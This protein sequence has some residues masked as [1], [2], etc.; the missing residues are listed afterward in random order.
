MK[1]TFTFLFLLSFLFV[2]AQDCPPGDVTFETQAQ[3]NSF[4]QQFP[5]CQVINGTLTL[6][7]TSNDGY[8]NI[9]NLSPLSNIT[10][11][12][13]DLVLSRLGNV[14]TLS[15]LSNLQ[16]VNGN[17][18]LRRNSNYYT[19]YSNFNYVQG[20]NSLTTITGTL[21]IGDFLKDLSGMSNLTQLGGIAMWYSNIESFE[22]LENITTLNHFDVQYNSILSFNGLQNLQTINGNF[23]LDVNP[24]TGEIIPLDLMSNLSNITTVTGD[25]YIT[26]SRQQMVNNMPSF[27]INFLSNLTSVGQNFGLVHFNVGDFSALSNL[28]SVGGNAGFSVYATSL[29]G[30][31]N[32]V[33]NKELYLSIDNV[34]DFS[35]LEDFTN[36]KNLTIHHCADLVSLNGLQ[37]LISVNGTISIQY[38]PFLSD[39]SAL[40]NVKPDFVLGNDNLDL[41]ISNNPSLST[42]TN[43]FVCGILR[44]PLREIII[45]NNAEGCSNKPTVFDACEA[46]EDVV[47]TEE[48][49]DYSYDNNILT[50]TNK[51]VTSINA[52]SMIGQNVLTTNMHNQMDMN[53][54][55]EGIYVVVVQDDKNRVYKLKVMKK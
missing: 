53:Q 4:I 41:I 30:L 6:R 10:T 43:D 27:N 23:T 35:G 55:G 26:G 52:F 14:A 50:V 44:L 42:C 34:T 54:L 25:F 37:N 28:Q 22:G 38:N 9:T 11:I 19:N 3:L 29:Q 46:I 32:Q 1:P 47:I 40:G 20:L 16:V 51:E 13:G 45:S 5:N 24:L 12:N 39:I 36:L 49:I 21:F 48:P 33:I 17:V 18:S 2:Q 7:H 31:S 15:G 8:S